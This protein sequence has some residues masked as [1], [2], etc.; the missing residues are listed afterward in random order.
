MAEDLFGNDTFEVRNKQMPGKGEMTKEETKMI[1]QI[2]IDVH[3]TM[4][5]MEVFSHDILQCLMTR[6]LYVRS[7]KHPESGYVQGMNDLI[8]PFVLVFL[9]EQLQKMTDEIS[10]VALEQCDPQ[11][12]KNAEADVYW[13][14][15][16]V[17]DDVADNFIEG[18]PGIHKTISKMQKLIEQKEAALLK[19]LDEMDIKFMDFAYRWTHCYL[20]REF[21]I[22]QIIRLWDTYFSEEEGFSQFHAYVC[23]A[24]FL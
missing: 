4:P 14:L 9:G 22:Y 12:L 19:S 1:K 13:C 24:L 7:Y 11:K 20:M 5:E 23:S 6:V 8:A 18:Q 3:R 16:R 21:D 10:V 15:A 17:I 2:K